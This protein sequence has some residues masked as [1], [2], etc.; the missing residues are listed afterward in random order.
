MLP[1][2]ITAGTYGRPTRHTLL[3]AHPFLKFFLVPVFRRGIDLLGATCT[4]MVNL[5]LG[6]RAV[7]ISTTGMN[8]AVFSGD[9][10][11]INKAVPVQRSLL[12]SISRI[13]EQDP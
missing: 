3:L 9:T 7:R 1:R 13:R 2:T 8:S 6:S 12:K 10:A 4:G 5:C 11:D